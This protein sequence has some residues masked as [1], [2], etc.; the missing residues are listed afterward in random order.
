M[1]EIPDNTIGYAS[2]IVQEHHL[3]SQLKDSSLAPVFS[4]PMLVAVMENAALNAIKPFFDEGETALGTAIELKHL[5]ATPLGFKVEATALVTAVNGR[6]ITF[7][8]TAVDGI[9]LIGEAI[10]ERTVI[11]TQSFMDK[12]SK[13]LQLKP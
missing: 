7:K 12:L 10:H 9:D 13:K 1:R 8:I 2:L 6:K 11:K 3:A 4:T 5:A